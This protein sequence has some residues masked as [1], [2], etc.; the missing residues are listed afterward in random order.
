MLSGGLP[1]KR[2]LL[3]HSRRE[4]YTQKAPAYQLIYL[5]RQISDGSERRKSLSRRYDRIV[6][7]DRRIVC[8]TGL[9]DLFICIAVQ[10]LRSQCRYGLRL[11]ENIG[12]QLRQSPQI[13]RYLLCHGT[14]EHP[15]VRPWICHQLFLIQLLYELERLIGAYLES[16]GAVILYLG[17]I[18]EQRR[19]L[20]LLLFLLFQQ[21]RLIRGG[22]LIYERL[23]VLA[24]LKAVLLVELRRTRIFAA[25]DSPPLAGDH[26]ARICP[27]V[28]AYPCIAAHPR[29]AASLRI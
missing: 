26:G 22:Y 14:G 15:R 9:S 25:I 1:L 21:G 18:V 11:G 4:K 29:L 7:R 23:R 24:P 19:I 13:D 2:Q 16:F 6:I 17:E 10:H 5:F 12:R 27:Y 3:V 28:I 8:I 20:R